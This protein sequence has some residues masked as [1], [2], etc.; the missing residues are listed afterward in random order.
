MKWTIVLAVVACAALA[1][2]GSAQ[3]RYPSRPVKLVLPQPAGGAVDLIARA[4]ADRLSQQMGQPF[5]VENM[6]GAN[7]SLA[8]GNV[9]RSPSDGYTLMMAVDSNL[10][11]NPSLYH[12]LTYDPFKDFVPIGIVARLNMVLVANPSVSAN[13]VKE[14]I[15]YAKANPNKLNYAEIGIGSAM[16]MGM[17]QFKFMTKTEINRVSYRGTAPAITDVVAGTVDLMFSGP[18]SAKSMSEGGKLKV[19]AVASPERIALLPDVPTVAE[20]GVPGYTMASW[21]GVVA[22]AKTPTPIV[23]RLSAEIK[24]AVN[25][26]VF[27]DRMKSVGLEIDGGSPAAMLETMRSDTQRWAELIKATGITIP[28]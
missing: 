20:A 27:K 3:D 2:P 12:T 21:F 4:L 8:G 28:Q 5:V 19:L 14:L 6:P 1:A 15:A 10:V 24:T 17:E 25:N 22:P 9:A 7:G 26:Q 16:H 23:E 18:P 13:S 11:I